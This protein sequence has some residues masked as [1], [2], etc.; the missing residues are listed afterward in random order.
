MAGAQLEGAEQGQ[1]ARTG[2]TNEVFALSRKYDGD[3]LVRSMVC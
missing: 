1:V 2:P 3:S